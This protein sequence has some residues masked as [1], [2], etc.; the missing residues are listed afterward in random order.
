MNCFQNFRQKDRLLFV[1][2][3]FVAA[4][5][6]A[7]YPSQNCVAF[8][9]KLKRWWGSIHI[10]EILIDIKYNVLVHVHTLPCRLSALLTIFSLSV[11]I[12]CKETPPC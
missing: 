4:V 5:M 2:S 10:S 11:V 6:I 7:R 12:G 3:S 9:E 8:V 1:T